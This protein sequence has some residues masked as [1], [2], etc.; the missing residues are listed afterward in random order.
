MSRY[1]YLEFVSTLPRDIAFLSAAGGCRALE[2][3]MLCRKDRQKLP[4]DPAE[5][6]GVIEVNDMA[7]FQSPQLRMGSPR[8]HFFQ[9]LLRGDSALLPA[10]QKRRASG[11]EPVL[12]MIAIERFLRFHQFAG[13]EGETPSAGN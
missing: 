2:L 7:A 8:C 9:V 4:H 11:R 13:I 3:R 6:G 5:S 10:Q 1:I 12:P